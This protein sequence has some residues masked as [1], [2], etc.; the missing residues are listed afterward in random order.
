VGVQKILGFFVSL[1]V[2]SLFTIS[3]VLSFCVCS[4]E[5]TNA[6]LC[7]RKKFFFSANLVFLFFFVKREKQKLNKK[8]NTTK[9]CENGCY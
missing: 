6:L 3:I 4:F 8:Q 7:E 2:F 5:Y 1:S 9:D